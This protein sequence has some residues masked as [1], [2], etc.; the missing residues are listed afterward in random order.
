MADAVL[1]AVVVRL[2]REGR[3]VGTGAQP[4]VERP[5]M[6]TLAAAERR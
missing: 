2:E 6:A 5:P 3:L 1:A 4:P